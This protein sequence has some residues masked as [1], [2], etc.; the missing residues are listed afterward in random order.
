MPLFHFTD[1]DL[2]DAAKACRAMAYQD[3]E[4]AKQMGNPGIRQQFIES[5]RRFTEL[6]AKLEKARGA[7]SVT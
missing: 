6:A 2:R 5:A 3:E 4:R 7:V 1:T